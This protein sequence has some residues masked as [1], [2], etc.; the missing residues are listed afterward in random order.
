MAPGLFDV[1]A[2][3]LEQHDI[4]VAIVVVVGVNEGRSFGKQFQS[5]C[6]GVF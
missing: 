4:E 3:S 6:G 1:A 2:E 5:G